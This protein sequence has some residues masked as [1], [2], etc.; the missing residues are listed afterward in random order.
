MSFAF[1][2]AATA[3]M[4]AAPDHAVASRADSGAGQGAQDQAGDRPHRPR[5]ARPASAQDEMDR[6]RRD[7]EAHGEMLDAWA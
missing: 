5:A 7:S 6:A 4:P 2:H 1:D 3:A